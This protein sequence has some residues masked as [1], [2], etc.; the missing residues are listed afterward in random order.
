MLAKA[1]ALAAL[2]SVLAL[3]TSWPRPGGGWTQTHEIDSWRVDSVPGGVSGASPSRRVDYEKRTY[4]YRHS[5]YGPTVQS[6]FDSAW[7]N[8]RAT[9]RQHNSW[10]IKSGSKRQRKDV[11]GPTGGAKEHTLNLC[12]E[13]ANTAYFTVHYPDGTSEEFEIGSG[14][15][16][17]V[18]IKASSKVELKATVSVLPRLMS[19]SHVHFGRY[20]K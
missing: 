18:W 3:E 12:N 2:S 15:M 10:T 11:P 7:I 16:V 6:Q 9:W 8:D 20:T 1:I 5:C 4:W 19:K 14:R 13:D 17:L